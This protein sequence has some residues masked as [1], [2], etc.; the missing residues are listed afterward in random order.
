MI[1]FNDTGDQ[2]LAD[3]L[4]EDEII[5]S[6]RYWEQEVAKQKEDELALAKAFAPENAPTGPP[7]LRRRH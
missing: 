1:A 3:D 5:Q 6:I 2:A 7:R 4:F